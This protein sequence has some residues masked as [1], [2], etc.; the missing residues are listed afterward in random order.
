MLG[1]VLSIFRFGQ[2]MEF[3][4]VEALDFQLWALG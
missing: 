3:Y 2:I 4:S 1:S